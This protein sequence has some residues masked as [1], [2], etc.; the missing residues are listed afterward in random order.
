M[1][2]ESQC[3]GLGGK[4]SI[5]QEI[6]TEVSEKDET[7]KWI[8]QQP[9]E[10]VDTGVQEARVDKR[11][12]KMEEAK[13]R[14]NLER[15][16]GEVPCDTCLKGETCDRSFFY[17]SDDDSGRLVC[18]QWSVAMFPGRPPGSAVETPKMCSRRRRKQPALF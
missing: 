15:P 18:E 2:T 6:L 10:S 7:D 17:V 8:K 14:A 5:S 11:D 12:Q 3:Q 13:E 4:V 1:T 9:S 16:V